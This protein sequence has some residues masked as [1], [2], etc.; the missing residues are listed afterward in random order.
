MPG[1]PEDARLLGDVSAQTGFIALDL[2]QLGPDFTAADVAQ[3]I[4]SEG[5]PDA[6]LHVVGFSIGAMAAIRIAGLMPDRVTKLTLISP[7]APLQMG[8]FLPEM[9]GKAVFDMAQRRPWLLLLVAW[10]QG[11]VARLS[12]KTL[13]KLLFA[14]C[15]PAERAL[16]D[17]PAFQEVLSAAFENS[18]IRSPRGYSAYLHAYVSDWTAALEAVA[19][20]VELWHGSQDTWSP[21]AMSEALA[22]AFGP[23]SQVMIVPEAEHYSTLTHVELTHA[24]QG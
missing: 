3:A 4:A 7:A 1:S 16:L 8:N 9:A 14:K 10:A 21:A 12:P 20:P 11:L 6:D 22:S 5:Q 17:D 2:L 13:N 18:L 19:C 24:E 23:S 15:G